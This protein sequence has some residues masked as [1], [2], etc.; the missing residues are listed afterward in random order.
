MFPSSAPPPR[1]PATF[2]STTPPSNAP[3]PAFCF[4]PA[5]TI[6]VIT[7]LA[8]PLSSTSVPNVLQ[9]NCFKDSSATHSCAE[10]FKENRLLVSTS[11]HFAKNF[12][13]FG[14]SVFYTARMLHGP[15]CNRRRNQQGQRTPQGT[16]ACSPTCSR[17][18]LVREH[19]GYVST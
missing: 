19:P 4:F 1:S 12:G 18:K 11:S 6:C 14:N 2:G 16:E 8:M 3:S 5:L 15:S 17:P 13:T 7:V 10:E 9:P